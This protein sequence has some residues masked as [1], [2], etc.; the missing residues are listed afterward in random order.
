MI[1]YRN[2]LKHEQ[3]KSASTINLRISAPGAS[4][5]WLLDQGY[6]TTDA[7]SLVS[8]LATRVERHGWH[9]R[10][11]DENILRYFPKARVT[12]RPSPLAETVVLVYWRN[13][14]LCYAVAEELRHDD[15]S[16]RPYWFP[17][18]QMGE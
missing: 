16:Y 3:Q 1:G 8:Q 14:V 4:C 5:V 18:P 13:A 10:D 11:Y 9:Y 7:H 17:Y 2:Y 12:V 6:L 15:G